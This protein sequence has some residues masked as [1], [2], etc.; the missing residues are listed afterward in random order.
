MFNAGFKSHSTDEL[1]HLDFGRYKKVAFGLFSTADGA[2]RDL[3]CED[4]VDDLHELLVLG[5]ITH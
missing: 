1:V 3:A 4:L 2:V 5:S